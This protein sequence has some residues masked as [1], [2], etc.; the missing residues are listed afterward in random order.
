MLFKEKTGKKARIIIVD[1]ALNLSHP[2]K[3]YQ[4]IYDRYFDRRFNN[5][6]IKR[7]VGEFVFTDVKQG[8]SE[9]FSRFIDNPSFRYISMEDETIRNKI[10]GEHFQLKEIPGKKNK[11]KFIAKR[12]LGMA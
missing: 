10:A 4:V 8:L 11:I 12:L 5:S 7:V 2:I 9:C 1:K 6:K 3:K